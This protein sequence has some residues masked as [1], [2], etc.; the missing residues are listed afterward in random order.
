MARWYAGYRVVT[1][2]A[3]NQEPLVTNT[4]LWHDAHR[5]AY[6]DPLPAKGHVDVLVIGGGLTGLTSALLLARAGTDVALV[7]ARS[8]AAGTT[9]SSTAKVS[10][11]QGTKLSRIC[12]R[13][14]VRIVR[15]Y[16]DANHEGQ[17]WLRGFCEEHDVPFALRPA[18][19]YAATP[20][21][22]D[23]VRSEYDALEEMGLPVR[24]SD[25]LDVPFDVHGAAVL[26]DQ[27]QLDPLDVLHALAEQVLAHGGTVHEG[28]RVRSV[29]HRDRIVVT[30]AGG[31]TLSADRL[32]IATGA[33]TLSGWLWAAKTTPQR[34]YLL[35]LENAGSVPGMFI[36][37]GD[38][39][40]S[41]RTADPRPGPELLLVGG[42]GH[43]VGRTRSE[44]H[45]LDELR[46]WA[47]QHFPGSVETHAWSA[48]DY[49]T[50][51]EL[52]MFGPVPGTDKRIHLASGYD[53]WGMTN[54]VCAARAITADI[55]GRPASWAEHL[56]S[57]S[58]SARTIAS[59]ARQGLFAGAVQTKGFLGA[60]LTSLPDDVPSGAGA[61]GRSGLRPAGISRVGGTECTVSAVCTHMGGILRWNDQ[62]R[63]WDC[64]LHGSRF[65]ADGEVI[66]GPATKPL[67]KLER[68]D[69]QPAGS[70]RPSA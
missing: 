5:R 19:T 46:R 42:H 31:G 39:V 25:A 28:Q 41:V 48:Q 7:E 2:P 17:A 67:P 44:A 47:Q 54:A 32:I 64:P 61:V 20:A 21:E 60:E 57:R 68:D 38:P 69:H 33:P 51:D 35:A 22:V 27:V 10:L 11:L 18:G 59:L 3:P 9:G 13:H 26:D 65:D 53:K 49:G 12:D 58:L 40:R 63:S 16:V 29:T 14:P 34:S 62:E 24:W 45:H 6:P 66:E 70:G 1:P 30:F 56:R 43:I 4:S 50:P 15:A 55:L 52:P 8:I 36:S 37:A 23:A